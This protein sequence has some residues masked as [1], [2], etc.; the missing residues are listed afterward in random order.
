MV[1][2][3][4]RCAYIGYQAVCLPKT[5]GGVAHVPM[6]CVDA[7]QAFAYLEAWIKRHFSGH[8]AVC[9]DLVLTACL[10]V[11]LYSCCGT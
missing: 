11:L 2:G 5:G 4:L 10:I 7:E 8:Y 9:P 3:S 1:S 6:E